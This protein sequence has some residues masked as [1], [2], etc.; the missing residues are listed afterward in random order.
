MLG[1]A[2]LLFVVPLEMLSYRSAPLASAPNPTSTSALPDDGSTAPG[3]D[4]WAEYDRLVDMDLQR[5]KRFNIY[6]NNPDTL[7]LH[8]ATKVVLTVASKDEATA[9]DTADRAY[10][11][12]KQAQAELGMHVRAELVGAEEDVDIQQVGTAERSISKGSNTTW[13]WYVTP[14]TTNDFEMTLRMYNLHMAGDQSVETEGPAY[15]NVFH[16][17]ATFGQKIKLWLS[18]VNGWLA[19]LGGSIVAFGGWAIPK[20]KAR[21]WPDKAGSKTGTKKAKKP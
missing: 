15:T 2:I 5:L 20:L 10:G 19:L 17:R 1:L 13:E 6:H 18:T 21:Y 12:T 3:A 9:R 4:S 11:P 14:K 7:P 8:K 16:V